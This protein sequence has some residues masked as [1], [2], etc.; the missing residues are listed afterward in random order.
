[1]SSEP[2]C[3]SCLPVAG[4][5]L[6]KCLQTAEIEKWEGEWGGVGGGKNTYEREKRHYFCTLGH[7][8]NLNSQH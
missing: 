4:A 6:S 2:I 5:I 8:I 7:L 3:F 1:M